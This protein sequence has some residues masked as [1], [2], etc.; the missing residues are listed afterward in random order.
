MKYHNIPSIDLLMAYKS[1]KLTGDELISVERAISLNPMVAGVAE[2]MD[3]K[4]VPLTK[5]IA[6]RIHESFIIPKLKHRGFW[7]K[8]AGWI[9]LSSIILLL[10]LYGVTEF[11]KPEPIYTNET[12]TISDKEVDPKAEVNLATKEQSQDR[13]EKVAVNQLQGVDE[14]INGLDNID[15]STV[16]DGSKDEKLSDN[17]TS[18]QISKSDENNTS[19]QLIDQDDK[20]V[21]NTR[22]F[23]AE[24]KSNQSVLLAVSNVQILSK[25]NPDAL[26]TRSTGGGGNPLGEQT[27]SSS[28]S[29]SVSDIPSFP[30]GDRA[31]NNYFR[32]KLRPIEIPNHQDKFDRTVL[33]E[34]TINSRGKLKDY[35]IRGQLHPTHQSALVEAIEELP[36]FNKGSEKI[37]YSLGVSF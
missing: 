14:L 12:M 33:I 15:D 2:S 8:Y 11:M 34:L 9:G 24:N 36:H 18:S 32:G 22:E 27:T 10:G 21:D 35:K 29:F 6:D 26:N 28:N 16:D 37:T 7:T 5:S 3:V 20:G 31:L 1:G 30:G 19:N 25:S 23:S 17:E 4:N 13:G